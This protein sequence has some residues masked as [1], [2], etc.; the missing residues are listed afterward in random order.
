MAIYAVIVDAK[1]NAAKQFYERFGFAS[2]QDDSM[3][4]FLPLGSIHL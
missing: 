4:L 3:R 2:M 1:N